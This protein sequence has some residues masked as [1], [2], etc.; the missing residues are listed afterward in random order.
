MAHTAPYDGEYSVEATCVAHSLV[1][2][3]SYQRARE[4][5][6]RLP[7]PLPLQALP[8]PAAAAPATPAP[9]VGL[10]WCHAAPQTQRG[11]S[12]AARSCAT[13]AWWTY[14]IAMHAHKSCTSLIDSAPCAPAR[15]DAPHVTLLRGNHAARVFERVARGLWCGRCSRGRL[16]ATGCRVV[17][18]VHGLWLAFRAGLGSL[19]CIL[20]ARLSDITRWEAMRRWYLH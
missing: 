3:P 1:Y 10:A 5:A 17:A 18:R 9:Q 11:H 6:A 4:A 7:P 19:N 2:T 8:P 15:G 20:L 14:A 16:F 13:K 12:S